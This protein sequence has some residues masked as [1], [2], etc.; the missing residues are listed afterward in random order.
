MLFKSTISQLAAPNVVNLVK[1]YLLHVHST[2]LCSSH[3]EIT[4]FHNILMQGSL[5][6]FLQ[7]VNPEWGVLD[8][9]LSGEVQR[10]PSYPDTV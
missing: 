7:G 8:I 1:H 6:L 3:L 5:G 4:P 9:S 2:V 10:G